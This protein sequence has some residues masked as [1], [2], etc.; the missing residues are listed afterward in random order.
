LDRIVVSFEWHRQG[1]QTVCDLLQPLCSPPTE[2]AEG[3]VEGDLDPATAT[4]QQL[5]G[6]A[7][8]ESKRLIGD[9]SVCSECLGD[10]TAE[11][12]LFGKCGNCGFQQWWSGF[13]GVRCQ[14]MQV[15]NDGTESVRDG[16]ST[17]WEQQVTWDTI[18]PGGNGSGDSAEDSDLRHTVCGTVT[19]FLDAYELVHKNWIPHRPHAAQAKKAEGEFHQNATP[20]Q[21]KNDSDWSENGEIVVRMQMQSESWNIKYYSLLISITEFLVTAAWKDREGVLPDKAEVTVQPSDA[22][23]DSI[24]YVAGSFYAV[25]EGGSSTTGPSVEYLV[26][27][28][29]GSCITVPCHRLR[30]RVWHRTAFLGVTNE[31]RHVAISTQAFFTKQ[32]K[33]WKLWG[34][35]GHDAALAYAAGDSAAVPQ[36]NNDTTSGG[37]TAMGTSSSHA[38]GQPPAQAA[39]IAA[40]KP[41]FAKFLA[42]LDQEKFW[43][44]VGHA[45]NATHFKSSQNLHWWSHQQDTLGF[46]RSIW[47]QYGCPG[48]GKGPWDGLG[49]VVKTKVRNDITNDKCLTPS[50]RVQNAME[51]AQHLRAT[52]STPDWMVKHAGMKVN[53]MVVFYIDKD[54]IKW[55]T[56]DPKYSTLDG[57]SKQYCFMMRGGGRV[58][59]RRYSCWCEACCLALRGGEG[60]TPRLDIPCCKRRALTSFLGAE[61]RIECKAA[62]GLT[63]AKARQKALWQQLKPL[64]KAGKFGA[65][66]ARELWSKEER[67]HL[68]PGHFWAC[69]FGDADGKGSPILAGPFKER[70]TFEGQR[71][72][73]EECAILLRRYYHRTPDDPD[74]L[75]FVRWEAEKGEKLI[76]NS[77]EL[78]AVQGRVACDFV[79]WPKITPKLKQRRGGN[80]A[81]KSK[82]SAQ[83]PEETHS[84]NQTWH[85]TQETDKETRSDCEA[86]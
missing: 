39:A 34:E 57:I 33:F 42:A 20:G 68:R 63:N 21:L 2:D 72:D 49:A 67:V 53:E 10:G 52:F 11:G 71:Y 62:P 60:V 4:L 65:V 31:K 41:D 55:P 3:G 73:A 58:A 77:S 54:E 61:Q 66:Q 51:V 36:P 25:V 75:T 48:K 9:Q 81:A 47:V 24:D 84:P 70:T 83:M 12:C 80:R 18:K 37:A 30:H 32:L 76:V 43:A 27:Q 19:E 46:I 56:V 40:N 29:D 22:L 5:A 15:N 38:T 13:N 6:F 1:L 64:L 45:D 14:V 44:W 69:E 35:Q 16:V 23:C 50:K 59:P 79:L 82:G 28:L 74:G 17:L 86:T 26:K 78:R 8:L 7:A 85:V